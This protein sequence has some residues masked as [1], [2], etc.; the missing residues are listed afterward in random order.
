MILKLTRVTIR[1]SLRPAGCIGNQKDCKV[2]T[3][4]DLSEISKP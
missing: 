3:V 1:R 2:K 4:S